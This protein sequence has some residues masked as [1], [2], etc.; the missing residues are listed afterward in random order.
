MKRTLDYNLNQFPDCA[1][2]LFFMGRYHQLSGNIDMAIDQ[3]EKSIS[4][5]SELKQFH[6][7]ANWDLLWCFALKGEW[8]RAADIAVI[9]RDTCKWSPATNAYQHA[10]FVQMIIDTEGRETE[11]RPEVDKAMAS[12]EQLRT[13]YGGKTLPPEKFAITMAQRYCQG[14]KTSLPALMLFYIWNIFGHCRENRNLME[15]LLKLINEQ[16]DDVTKGD[17]YYSLL[18]LKGVCLRNYRQSDEAIECFGAILKN[19]KLIVKETHVAPHAAM[20]LGLTLLDIGKLAD[21]K[22]WLEKARD[23]YNGFLIET[24]VHLRIHGAL[25]KL[26]RL[27]KDSNNN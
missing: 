18:L 24:A 6:S 10:C 9:L 3:F 20:E 22:L 25:Q 8:R 2:D 19:E 16:L 27:K 7:V 5:Q 12:V 4:V 15:P 17:Q 11:L 13:R 26:Q 23:N 14:E 1:F 21:A